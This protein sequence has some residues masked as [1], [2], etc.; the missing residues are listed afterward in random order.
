MVKSRYLWYALTMELSDKIHIRVQPALVARRC[1]E[2]FADLLPPL[3]WPSPNQSF[4]VLYCLH[5]HQ[6][7]QRM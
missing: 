6:S 3:K 2:L 4:P 1:R 5:P 7:D